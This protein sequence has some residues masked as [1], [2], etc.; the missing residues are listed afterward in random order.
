MKRER[1]TQILTGLL[2]SLDERSGDPVVAMVGKVELFG[3]YARGAVEPGDVDVNVV[4]ES[5]PALEFFGITDILNERCHSAIKRALV[6]NVRKVN[7][8]FLNNFRERV[9]DANPIILWEKGDELEKALGRLHG[10]AEDPAA[11][12]APRTH[13][14]PAFE[15]LDAWLPVYFRQRII[16]AVE[17]GT[18]TVEQVTIPD[19]QAIDR[20]IDWIIAERW[21]P[22]GPLHR[23]AHAVMAYYHARGLDPHNVHLH[24]QDIS[25]GQARYSAGFSCRYLREVPRQFTD[26]GVIEHIE[27]LHPT[28]TKPLLALKITAADADRFRRDRVRYWSA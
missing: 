26:H 1:A 25:D 15:G 9:P 14:L 7:M 18:V 27:I 28:P 19:G 24:G 22:G 20:E 8:L 10:I 17:S 23:A 16:A 6:G 2:H 21:K 13:M 5:Q 11:G 3:S 4:Y 12:R